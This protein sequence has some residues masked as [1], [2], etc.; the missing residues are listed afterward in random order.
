MTFIAIAMRVGTATN[1]IEEHLAGSATIDIAARLG[2]TSDELQEF[3]DGGAPAEM[4]LQLGTTRGSVQDLRER[5]GKE[6]AIGFLLG[7]AVA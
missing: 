1:S 4:A 3:I 5:L 7:L 6:G 2:M